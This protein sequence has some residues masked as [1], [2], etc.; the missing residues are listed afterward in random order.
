MILHL[1][2]D[3]KFGE[4]AVK[5]FS[6]DDMCSEFIIVAQSNVPDCFRKYEGVKVVLEDNEEFQF[7]LQRLGEYKAIVLH[8][9]FY[10]WQERILQVVP[11]SVKVA[12]VFWGG[13]IYGR[14]CFSSRFLSL[15]SKCL[16]GLRNLKLRLWDRSND[17]SYELPFSCLQRIDYC[18]TDIPQDYEFVL[19]YFKTPIK[20]LW[21]NY[22]SIEDTIGDLSHERVHGNNILVGNSGSIECNHL[23]GFRLVSK[24]DTGE[25]SIIVPLSYGEP[26]LRRR[27]IT[28]GKMFF[29]NHFKPLTNFLPRDQYN[30]IITSCSVAVMPHYRPQAFGNILTAL[31][32]GSRVYL[33][34]KNPLLRYFRELG[35]IIFS[36]EHDLKRNNPAVLSPLSDEDVMKNRQAL[37][38]SYGKA[39]MNQKNI[40]IVKVL[41]Q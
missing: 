40:E 25:A 33:S 21:Y 28:L 10:P 2:F 6:G 8:G 38:L 7:L 31:W 1:L 36:I 24:L 3:D 39:V 11:A 41:N 26:W 22:Y 19:N 5:Q 16:R 23:D 30:R 32:L 37:S 34:E 14:K 15:S 4:Y 18:L 27:L 9:L 12:W 13:D 20:R 35:T 17:H 29:K